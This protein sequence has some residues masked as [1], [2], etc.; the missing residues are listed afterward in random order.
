MIS[1]VIWLVRIY[2]YPQTPWFSMNTSCD[3]FTVNLISSVCTKCVIDL[4]LIKRDWSCETNMFHHSTRGSH[5]YNVISRE[6]GFGSSSACLKLISSVNEHNL[7]VTYVWNWH[8]I[9]QQ[10]KVSYNNVWDYS[11]ITVIYNIHR[12]VILSVWLIF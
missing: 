10:S 3:I 1:M 8:T 6:N 2:P 9:V 11:H 5:E 12:A 4:Q 7:N